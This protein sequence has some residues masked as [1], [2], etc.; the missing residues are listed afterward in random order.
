MRKVNLDLY[1]AIDQKNQEEHFTEDIIILYQNK[2]Y[3]CNFKHFKDLLEERKNIKD[4][5]NFICKILTSNNIFPLRM[6]NG[7]ILP[8]SIKYIFVLSFVY[9]YLYKYYNIK[10]EDFRL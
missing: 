4:S 6:T 5:Y 2:Y 10:K 3:D 1:M 9:L 8:S 7:V